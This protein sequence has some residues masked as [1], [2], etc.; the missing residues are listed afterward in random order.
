MAAIEGSIL[1]A[2]AAWGMATADTEVTTGSLP[3]RSVA[4]GLTTLREGNRIKVTAF[5]ACAVVRAVPLP[6]RSMVGQ[7]TL[8]Q[9]IGVRIPGGQP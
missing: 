1:H 5:W 9:H 7:L 6:P 2:R 8:D 4:L 3:A